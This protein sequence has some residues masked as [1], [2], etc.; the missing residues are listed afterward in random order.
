VLPDLGDVS[1]VEVRARHLVD[2]FHKLR[3]D[4]KRNLAPWWPAPFAAA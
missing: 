1:L 2:L 4:Q 3:A